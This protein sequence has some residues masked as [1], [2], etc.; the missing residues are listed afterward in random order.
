MTVMNSIYDEM[1][2]RGLI[3]QT[4]NDEQ[5]KVLIDSGDAVFYWGTDPTGRSAHVGHLLG[6]VTIR[7][8]QNAGNRLI[9]LLGG[10][11]GLIGDPSGKSRERV[12][13]G[14]SE[15][16]TNQKLLLSTINQVINLQDD[17]TTQVV[18]NADW[19]EKMSIPTFLR[20]VGKNFSVSA[21]LRMD[22]VKSRLDSESGI[23]FTEFSY[24]LLQAY[25]FYHLY[26]QYGCNLQIGGSDQF[27]NIIAGMDYTRRRCGAKVHGLI[28]PL[29]TT[30]A[31]E[32]MG[33]TA[34]GAIWLDAELTSPYDFYQYWLQVD[35]TD[36]EQL[37]M[38]YTFVPVNEIRKI[39]M[40]NIIEAKQLL[41]YEVTA[42][43]HTP[44]I[45]EQAKIASQAIFSGQGVQIDGI[46]IP[47]LSISTNQLQ[48]G[49]EITQAFL[50][51]GLVTSKSAAR[52]LIEQ[53]GA[54]VNN[55]VIDDVE[56]LLSENDLV[57]GCII[58]RAGKK[59]YARI[60]LTN[61]NEG[62]V[63]YA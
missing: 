22:S 55:L 58:L 23:S 20:D 33:K 3:Q 8:L 14:E 2:E 52:R 13:L 30:N 17:S 47:E 29:V 48:S 46:G 44:E 41:A 53:G 6:L 18:N 50:D 31:G 56:N 32:K 21:M 38:L 49:L 60:K 62:E 36:V 19:F 37:L 51:T 7:R 15:I 10:A 39:V 34:K 12:L 27:A 11:T 16:N 5:I 45:A 35:D 25:D 24:S 4:T 40:E 54:Y 57:D 28:T 9:I 42:L 26:T 61:D 63:Y 59:K 43:V 1:K